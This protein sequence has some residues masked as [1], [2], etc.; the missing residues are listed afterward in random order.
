MAFVAT[1]EDGQPKL[2]GVLSTGATVE[3]FL[4]RI[5]SD[6]LYRSQINALLRQ[7]RLGSRAD[8]PVGAAVTP[9]NLKQPPSPV[10]PALATRSTG[11]STAAVYGVP[12]ASG[13]VST[14]QDQAQL[15]TQQT[16]KE[17]A[18]DLGSIITTLGG[19]YIQARFGQVQPSVVPFIPPSPRPIMQTRPVSAGD[20][21]G[22][23]PAFL[24]GLPALAGPAVRFGGSMADKIAGAVAGLG[25]GLSADEIAAVAG[26]ASKVKCRRKRRRLA[27]HSDI[28]DLAALKA[29]LGSGK[30]FDTWIATRRV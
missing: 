20:V 29:V 11:I 9:R 1:I 21:Y 25:I 10:L 16:P 17:Q 19:Q 5:K 13:G 6:Y 24:G 7:R 22:V 15:P 30:A 4:E 28:K 3:G 12:G 2:R 8:V 23:Q 26:V 14:S 27:T 18:M